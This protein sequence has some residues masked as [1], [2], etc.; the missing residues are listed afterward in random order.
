MAEPLE[1]LAQKK[2]SRL[3]F[4]PVDQKNDNSMASAGKSI[5]STSSSG[6]SW[7]PKRRARRR[8]SRH[9]A[10]PARRKFSR[11]PVVALPADQLGKNNAPPQRHEVLKPDLQVQP[12]PR[13]RGGEPGIR[14]AFRPGTADGPA[15]KTQVNPQAQPQRK[16]VNQGSRQGRPQAQ[17]QRREV[18]QGNRQGASSRQSQGQGAH[19][20]QSQGASND[21]SQA[22][23][24]NQPK[25]VNRRK[26]TRTKASQLKQSE[27][28]T[29]LK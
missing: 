21:Q 27:M 18:N 15:G 6:N 23:P 16:S 17:P 13:K 26:K 7:K 2:D 22:A 14:Q 4:Q 3:R 25:V 20:G 28:Q 1:E 5:G 24:R 10:G 11:S 12:Q 9:A 19:R 8:R 29:G